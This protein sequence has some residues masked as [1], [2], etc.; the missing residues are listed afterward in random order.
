MK[1][2]DYSKFMAEMLFIIWLVLTLAMS[3]GLFIG[4]HFGKTFGTKAQLEKYAQLDEA[5]DNIWRE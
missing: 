3:S 4:Y 5:L 1:K 2:G